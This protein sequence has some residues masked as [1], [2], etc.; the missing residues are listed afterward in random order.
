MYVQSGDV[1]E[2]IRSSSAVGS[3]RENIV[4]LPAMTSGMRT[5][6]SSIAAGSMVFSVT[7]DTT[8][9]TV[10]SWKPSVG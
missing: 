9:C 3:S 10:V 1:P 5:R 7:S 4:A 2:R 6:I 8:A